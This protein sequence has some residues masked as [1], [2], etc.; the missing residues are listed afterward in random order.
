M[1][2]LDKITFYPCLFLATTHQLVAGHLS[3]L[4]LRS[5]SFKPST[6][7]TILCADSCGQGRRKGGGGGGGGD[8][9]PPSSPGGGAPPP[10]NV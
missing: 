9:P 3:G 7:S 2:T 1:P 10:K 8:K 6:F 5:L 4:H